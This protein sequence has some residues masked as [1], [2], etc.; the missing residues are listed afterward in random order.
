MLTMSA[1]VMELTDAERTALEALA[2]STSLPHRVV[3]QAKGV[4]LAADGVANNEI[5]RRLDV[6]PNAVRRWRSK[7]AT[8][9]IAGVGRIRPGRGRKPE[10]APELIEAIVHD[11]LH[12]TPE[13][14]TH[15]S[16]RSMAEHAGVGKDTV[17]RIWRARNIRPWRVETF[18]LSNDP[19]FETKRSTSSACIWT[20]RS[21]RW[22]CA[23]TRS[24]NARPWNAVSRRCRSPP[25]EPAP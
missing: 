5:A 23:S 14:A 11:T 8:E 20:H 15:W 25:A 22:C 2:R 10:L 19:N 17:A 3:V 7:F 12:T 6:T 9:G 21:V 16:T 18:K 4:L 13:D 1:P 24:P